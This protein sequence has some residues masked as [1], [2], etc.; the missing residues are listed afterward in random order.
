MRDMTLCFLVKGHPPSEV[1]LD[2]KKIGFGQGKY[3][4]FGGKAEAGE[5]VEAAAMHELEIEH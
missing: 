3:A 1:L 4:G 2:L 5:T